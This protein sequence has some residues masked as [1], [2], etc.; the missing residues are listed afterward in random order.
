MNSDIVF[1]VLTP[2][3]AGIETQQAREMWGGGGGGA[4]KGPMSELTPVGCWHS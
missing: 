3:A 4:E 2:I 1:F